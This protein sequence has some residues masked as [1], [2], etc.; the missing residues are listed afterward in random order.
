MKFLLTIPAF[1][2]LNLVFLTKDRDTM[3]VAPKYHA[4]CIRNCHDASL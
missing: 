1:Y 3:L 4:I 2:L